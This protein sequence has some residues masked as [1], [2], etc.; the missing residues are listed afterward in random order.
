MSCGVGC[1]HGSDLASLWLWRRPAATGPIGPLA[2]ESTY[3][4]GAAQEMAKRPKKKKKKKR[5]S[6]HYP[7]VRTCREPRRYKE[8]RK[9]ACLNSAVAR[10]SS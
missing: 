10:A 3:D 7:Q 9:G 8:P 5:Q 6:T 4:T 1:R 2:W